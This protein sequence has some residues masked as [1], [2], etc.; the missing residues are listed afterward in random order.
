MI[1]TTLKRNQDLFEEGDISVLYARPV[2]WESFEQLVDD[3]VCRDDD[4]SYS[5]LEDDEALLSCD[6]IRV[7]LAS[8]STVYEPSFFFSCAG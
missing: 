2:M 1:V 7:Q 6:G 4:L 5:F 8:L 3:H